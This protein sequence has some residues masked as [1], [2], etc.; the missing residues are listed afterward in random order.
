MRVALSK[1]D[2]R[3]KLLFLLFF[4]IVIAVSSRLLF[5]LAGLLFT[6]LLTLLFH[7]SPAKLLR[8][9][10][11]P[12]EF[13]ALALFLLPFTVDG[14]PLF[15]LGPL[16]LTQEGLDFALLLFLRSS[17]IIWASALFL[18]STDPLEIVYALAGLG[19]PQKLLRIAFFA[20]RY[21]SVI[22]LEYNKLRKAM[23]ARGF[24][25]RT[26]L[27]TYKSYAYLLGMVL[28]R[29]Y[30]RAERVY[31]AMLARGFSGSFPVYRSFS[32]SPL[33]F[34]FITSAFAFLFAI[35]LLSWR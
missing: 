32:L 12:Q 22:D 35:S 17:T 33:D 8:R 14:R 20:L 19:I 27:H 26:D 11:V 2:V 29:S 23:K 4:S 15:T 16:A 5:I 10:L 21:I 18:S 31:K 34:Y 9:M 28:V 3:V 13:L 25:P 24:K 1:L 30:E 7:P 6:L